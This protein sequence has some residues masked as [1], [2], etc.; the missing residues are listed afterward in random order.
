MSAITRTW[1]SFAAI[2]TG[3]I[4]GAL[5]IGAPLGLGIP[6][7]IL[8]VVE[9]GWGVLAFTR[10]TLPAPRAAMVVAVAPLIVWGLLVAAASTLQSPALASVMDVVPW[11]VAAIFQLFVA[12]ILSLHARRVREGR[13][14]ARTVP[15]AARYLTALMVGGLVVSALTTPALAATEAGSYAQPHGE[16]DGSFTPQRDAPD[17]DNVDDLFTIP[18]HNGH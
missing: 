12:S 13:P 1:I 18:G 9:F 3:L 5:V 14:A 8:G 11:G 4:H 6:L 7:A 16:H 2:G 17:G 15:G 10:D